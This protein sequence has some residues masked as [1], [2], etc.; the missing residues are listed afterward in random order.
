MR[1]L[2]TLILSITFFSSCSNDDDNIGCGVIPEPLA[3]KGIWNLINVSCECE[4][5]DFQIGEHVWNFNND[6]GE[7]IVV[8]NPNEDLQILETGT[9]DFIA[10]GSK[11]TIQSVTY[12][13][14]FEN[15]KLFLA[16]HPE[17]DGPLLEFVRN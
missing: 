14:Y 17:I 2:F 5:V 8:N 9:Y 15:E 1:I 4:P 10:T 12:D 6:D 13:F 7:I 3:L 16:D 11:I